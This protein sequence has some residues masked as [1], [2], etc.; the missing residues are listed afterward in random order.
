MRFD[1]GA[2]CDE[3]L[4]PMCRVTLVVAAEMIHRVQASQ[5]DSWR[6]CEREPRSTMESSYCDNNLTASTTPGPGAAVYRTIRAARE[7]TY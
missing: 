7:G 4:S 2:G 6:V 3:C 1:N 5:G